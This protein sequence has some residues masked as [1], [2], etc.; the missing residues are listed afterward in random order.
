[1]QDP[2]TPPTPTLKER[3]YRARGV[4]S[5]ENL[6][7]NVKVIMTHGLMVLKT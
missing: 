5:R 7:V 3:N 1:M 2:R 6:G 4:K